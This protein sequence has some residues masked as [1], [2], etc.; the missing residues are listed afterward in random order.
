MT[1]LSFRQYWLERGI[2]AD[3]VRDFKGKGG[4]RQRRR[5]PEGRLGRYVRGYDTLPIVILA[6]F[7]DSA[8]AGGTD[9][10]P[11]MRGS[12]TGP[13]LPMLTLGLFCMA[14]LGC[15]GDPSIHLDP[16]GQARSGRNRVDSGRVSIGFV[17][18]D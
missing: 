18:Q 5:C 3:F 15:W 12:R 10:T 6:L 13:I 11:L 8:A 4:M 16:E 2:K 17:L 1:L 14:R 9:V 7:C